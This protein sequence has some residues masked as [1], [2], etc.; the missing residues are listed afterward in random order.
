MKLYLK[1]EQRRVSRRFGRRGRKERN[2]VI[3]AYNIDT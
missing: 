2:D 3:R 1:K